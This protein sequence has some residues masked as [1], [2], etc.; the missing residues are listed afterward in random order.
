MA[1]RSRT[2][3]GFPRT[4]PTATRELLRVEV[5]ARRSE[6]LLLQGTVHRFARGLNGLHGKEIVPGGYL[7]VPIANK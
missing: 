4:A 3:S 5:H 2:T 7:F 6:M 1:S